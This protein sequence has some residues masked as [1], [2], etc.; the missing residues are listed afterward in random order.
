MAPNTVIMKRTISIIA[1]FL[2]SSIT[3]FTI[4]DLQFISPSPNL[5]QGGG[6]LRCSHPDGFSPSGEM[7]RGQRGA[8]SL[9]L[10]HSSTTSGATAVD[11]EGCIAVGHLEGTGV[12]A[13]AFSQ[14][15]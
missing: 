14:G 11:D 13:V 3:H 8:V 12:G 5:P 2:F 7:S 4:Y 1:F 10:I 15:D 6:D 9:V